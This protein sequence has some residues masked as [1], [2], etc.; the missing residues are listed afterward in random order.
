M[1]LDPATKRIFLPAAEFDVV[2]PAEQGGRPKRT[3]KPGSFVVLVV[4]K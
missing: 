2:P 4:S 3:M 1:A